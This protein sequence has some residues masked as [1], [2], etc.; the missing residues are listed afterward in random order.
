L[1]SW[2]FSIF[3]KKQVEKEPTHNPNDDSQNKSNFVILNVEPKRWG[4]RSGPCGGYNISNP[5]SDRPLLALKPPHNELDLNEFPEGT[6]LPY[7]GPNP[8]AEITAIYPAEAPFSCLQMNGSMSPNWRASVGN[9]TFFVQTKDGHVTYMVSA[10]APR[11]GVSLIA[12]WPLY[13]PCLADDIQESANLIADWLLDRA[14]NFTSKIPSISQMEEQ[15]ANAFAIQS[16]EEVEISIRLTVP[17]KNLMNG[18]K[19][20]H[21]MHDLGFD[22]GAH[23]FVFYD[24]FF[25]GSLLITCSVYDDKGFEP[26][27]EDLEKGNQSF[28]SAT[29]YLNGLRTRSPDYI[30]GMINSATQ[31]LQSVFGGELEFN[32]NGNLVKEFS[33]LEEAIRQSLPSLVKFNLKAGSRAVKMLH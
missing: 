1:F 18:Q 17:Q 14:Q 26:Y 4:T 11:E 7:F 27:L 13:K 21:A 12:A 32:L 20:W 28:E 16:L 2:I 30:L 19:L 10:D 3:K 8:F 5:L 25:D 22:Y 23:D 33:I 6:K 29:F 24:P 15:I 31:E 9:P